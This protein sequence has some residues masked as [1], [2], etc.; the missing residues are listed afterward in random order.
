MSETYNYHLARIYYQDDSEQD[1]P[2]VGCV[3]D[4]DDFQVWLD[5]GQRRL[6][7]NLSGQQLRRLRDWVWE[8]NPSCEGPA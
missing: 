2:R 5:E 3:I 1:P 6:V 8:N 7:I 4:F